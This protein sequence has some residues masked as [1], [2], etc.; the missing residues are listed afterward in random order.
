MM[1]RYL[2]YYIC[3]GPVQWLYSQSIHELYH[4]NMS[5]SADSQIIHL[6]KAM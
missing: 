6:D 5:C 3:S 1:L 2:I 4:E